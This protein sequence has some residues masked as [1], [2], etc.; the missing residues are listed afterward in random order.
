M[1]GQGRTARWRRARDRHVAARGDA[2]LRGAAVFADG[3]A[4]DAAVGRDVFGVFGVLF[5]V[6]EAGRGAAVV[7]P[8]VVFPA[9]VFAMVPDAGDRGRDREPDLAV[10]E[11]VPS[12]VRRPAPLPER[13]R[14]MGRV[15]FRSLSGSPGHARP[16]SRASVPGRP[17]YSRKRRRPLRH[18]ADPGPQK[19]TISSACGLR[20][21]AS[22]Q[23]ALRSTS[24][25][26]IRESEEGAVHPSLFGTIRTTMYPTGW[27]HLTRIRG[28]LASRG[29]SRGHP[30]QRG[31]PGHRAA[32]QEEELP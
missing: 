26:V 21:Q 28:L 29:L 30:G 15:R 32:P 19:D 3:L 12:E 16:E 1:N 11:R 6:L 27:Q 2:R 31:Q 24:N 14:A 5:A 23:R 9:V 13:P 17:C 20:P 22:G 4:D 8:A 10:W 25:G 18:L 7:F